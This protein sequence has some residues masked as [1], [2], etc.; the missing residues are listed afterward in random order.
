MLHI[1]SGKGEVFAQDF[2]EFLAPTA[3][4]DFAEVAFCH[5][6]ERSMQQRLGHSLE[7]PPHGPANGRSPLSW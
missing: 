5:G 6:K 3:R 1:F 4:R 7:S 2:G